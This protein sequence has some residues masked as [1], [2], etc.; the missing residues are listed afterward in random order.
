MKGNN[1]IKKISNKLWGSAFEKEPSEAVIKFTAGRDVYS[2]APVDYKLLPYDIWGNKAHCVMLC[3]QKIISKKDA[4]VILKGLSEIEALSQKGKFILDPAKEDVHTNIEQWLIKKYGI[5]HAGKLHA[6][7]SRNDQCSLDTRLYLKDQVLAFLDKNILLSKSLIDQAQ[8]YQNYVMPGFTHH[9]HAMVTTFGHILTAFASMITRD[10]KRFISWFKLHNFNPLGNAVSYG[11]TF[12]ID[13][14]LTTK[15]LGFDFPE[16]NSLD[17]ITNRWEAEADLGFSITVLMNHLSLMAQTL[18]LFSTSEFGMVKLADQ[19]STGSSIMPQ[20]KNPDP[21]EVIKGK[22]GFSTG[23]LQ[24]LL[25]IGKA[26]FIGFN[27][28]SQWTKY[29][30]TDLADECLPA[31]KVV[32]EAI[33]TMKVNKKKMVHWCH[34]GFIG[35]TTLLEQITTQYQLPF[36]K[37]KILIEKAVKFSKGKEKVTYQALKKAIKEEKIAIKI[38]PKQVKKWQDPTEIIKLTKSFGGP[39]PK[40]IK[41]SSLILLQE[42][43]KQE[44]WLKEKIAQKKKAIKLLDKEI[45]KILGG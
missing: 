14:K 18:I 27:R 33:K 22:A 13:Q 38:S 41:K 17:G 43:K 30:I 8:K 34:I 26:N 11:T 29:L 16:V 36:R 7:R 12:S 4:Q 23:F 1:M 32:E 24:S 6:A 19:F 5:E 45:K 15:L 3:K 40:S 10:S 35:A 2:V 42:I 31:A 20:K 21:L 25:S 9:Q 28:D 39:N 44:K 37:V